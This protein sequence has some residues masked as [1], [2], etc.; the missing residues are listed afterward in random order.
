MTVL[1]VQV[2]ANI[3]DK[4]FEIPKG[5]DLKPQSAMENGG[6]GFRMIMRNN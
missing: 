4:E 2:D 1:K 6:G 3:E 5:Y